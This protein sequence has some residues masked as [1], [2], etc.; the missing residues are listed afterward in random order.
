MDPP[1]SSGTIKLARDEG[2][3]T[4]PVYR[5]CSTHSPIGPLRNQN[6]KL[7]FFYF[8]LPLGG[9]RIKKEAFF[10]FFVLFF[11]WDKRNKESYFST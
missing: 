7:L 2:P 3:N 5:I 4:R 11:F 10:F 6:I 9:V 1:I 8:T